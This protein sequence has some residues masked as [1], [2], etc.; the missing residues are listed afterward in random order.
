MCRRMNEDCARR[1]LD[2]IL[3]VNVYRK[4]RW[5][6]MGGEQFLCEIP[7]LV[8]VQNTSWLGNRRFYDVLTSEL[9]RAIDITST[10]YIQLVAGRDR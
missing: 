1:L 5:C 4:Q 7:Y 10:A 3:L 6:G 8:K 2:Y 9:G